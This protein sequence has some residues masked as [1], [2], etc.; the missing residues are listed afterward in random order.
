MSFQA[1][2]TFFEAPVK[3]GV[4]VVDTT[5]PVLTDNQS[6]T[7]SDALTEF[8]LV[9]LSFGATRE[10]TFCGPMERLR[11]VLTIEVFTA[12]GKGPGRGQRIAEEVMKKLNAL[13]RHLDRTVAG[14]VA[15]SINTITGP[16]F[17]ALDGRPHFYTRLSCSLQASYT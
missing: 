3:T 14:T 7:D 5:I 8:V 15:G 10:T 17:S 11:G 9:R 6:Y 13:P 4:A 1:I 12:K 2:R 16:S